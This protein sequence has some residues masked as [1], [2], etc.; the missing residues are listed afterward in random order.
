M[1]KEY[2]DA[3][4][5]S[6]HVRVSNR[7]ALQ[8]YKDNLGFEVLGIEKGY[9]ADREDAYKMKKFFKDSEKEKEKDKIIQL[10]DDLKWED[11][12]DTFEEVD[13]K[14]EEKNFEAKKKVEEDLSTEKLI[15]EITQA[16]NTTTITATTDKGGKKKNKKKK[17]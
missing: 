3:N 11:I 6:L 13:E 9:Y 12:K 16:G 1:M 14:G 15:E 17:K 7:P 10:T 2:Y 4:F 8:L 5:V